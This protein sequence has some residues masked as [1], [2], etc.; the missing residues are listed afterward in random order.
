MLLEQQVRPLAR[1]ECFRHLGRYRFLR[2]PISASVVFA[3]R[4]LQNAHQHVRTIGGN[5]GNRGYAGEEQNAVGARIGDGVEPLQYL[6]RMRCRAD[7]C[8]P[9][10]TAEFI[11]NPRRD[12]L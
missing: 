11:L 9:Q 6:T 12:L 8:T 1:I 10:V 4:S 5:G 7:E 2:L 3:L